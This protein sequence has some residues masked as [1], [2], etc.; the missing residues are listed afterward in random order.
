MDAEVC[1][2][3]TVF[4][5]QFDD[6]CK[7]SY[8]DFVSGCIYKRR[9]G[10]GELRALLSIWLKKRL[11]EGR[12]IADDS[13]LLLTLVVGTLEDTKGLTTTNQ[14]YNEKF[15]DTWCWH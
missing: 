3:M 4:I 15:C 5:S 6:I 13:L 1:I 8:S 12:L 14:K 9:E 7:Y 2:Y 11:P 10:K